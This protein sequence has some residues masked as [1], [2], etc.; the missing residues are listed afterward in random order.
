M[1][2]DQAATAAEKVMRRIAERLG[3]DP[4]EVLTA[5]GLL[6][7]QRLTRPRLPAWAKRPLPTRREGAGHLARREELTDDDLTWMIEHGYLRA[8]S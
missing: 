5:L 7:T 8:V 2:G 4:T 1:T 6:P 3:E